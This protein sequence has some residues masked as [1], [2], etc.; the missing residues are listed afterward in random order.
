MSEIEYHYSLIIFILLLINCLVN[1]R[2][3]D[4]GTPTFLEKYSA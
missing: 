1:I 3:L 4:I 2:S